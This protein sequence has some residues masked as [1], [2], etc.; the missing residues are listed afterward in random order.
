MNNSEAVVRRMRQIWCC[1]GAEFVRPELEAGWVE[2]QRL[3][4]VVDTVRAKYKKEYEHSTDLGREI[5]RLLAT[6]VDLE[7]EITSIQA[8][9]T[10]RVAELELSL[11]Y[12]ETELEGPE[13]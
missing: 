6:I 3:Q 2:I 8:A 10:E 9:F 13:Q 7:G 12:A 4:K 5:D 1:K 11:G